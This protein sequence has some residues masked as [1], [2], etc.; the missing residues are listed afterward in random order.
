MDRPPTWDESIA[1]AMLA[2][3]SNAIPMAG[4]VIEPLLIIYDDVRAR[5]AHRAQ[6][7][8]GAVAEGVGGAEHL[9]QRLQASPEHET[10]FVQAVEEA[11]RTGHDAKRR[12]LVRAVVNSLQHDERFDESQLIIDALAQL[13]VMHIRA[14]ARLDEELGADGAWAVPLRLDENGRVIADDELRGNGFSPAWRAL[15][16]PLQAALVRAGVCNLYPSSILAPSAA[17]SPME[18]IN[19]FGRELLAALRMETGEHESEG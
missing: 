12:L 9:G 3:A 4:A 8:L 16:S 10:Q 6:L 5:R 11:I 7:V 17:P 19:S 18:G 13:E 15:P 14:L 2:L 1:R